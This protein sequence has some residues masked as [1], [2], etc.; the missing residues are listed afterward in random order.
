M[1]L[2]AE[3]FQIWNCLKNFLIKNLCTENIM[4]TLENSKKRKMVWHF[5][6]FKEKNYL[7]RG[8]KW[9]GQFFRKEK[10]PGWKLFKYRKSPVESD[11]IWDPSS[12]GQNFVR[13]IQKKL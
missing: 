5:R 1:R 7:R 6:G 11:K 10:A 4:V 9:E 3:N 12:F 2:N 8:S 13:M